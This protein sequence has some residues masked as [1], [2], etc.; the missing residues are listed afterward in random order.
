[1][2]LGFCGAG[3]GGVGGV[4]EAFEGVQPTITKRQASRNSDF[5]ITE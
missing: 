2:G 5:F 3:L 4:G 1:M